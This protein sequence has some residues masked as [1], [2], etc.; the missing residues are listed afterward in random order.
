MK[1][2]CMAQ[3]NMSIPMDTGAFRAGRKSWNQLR[4]LPQQNQNNHHISWSDTGFSHNCLLPAMP[5]AYTFA[6]GSRL[7][8]LYLKQL[9]LPAQRD[10][11]VRVP[12]DT[13]L[14]DRE[15]FSQMPIG[16]VWSDAKMVECFEY[17]YT[18][19]H[20]RTCEN[21]LLIMWRATWGK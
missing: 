7:R 19:H 2:P 3:V 16:D 11:R 15:L 6:Y 18:N 13:T 4:A 1:L 10:L 21:L 9:Q 20:C 8:E 5:R 12:V 17:L 14:S